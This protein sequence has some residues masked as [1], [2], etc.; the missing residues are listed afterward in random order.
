MS[1][2]FVRLLLVAALLFGAPYAAMILNRAMGPWSVVAIEADG[3]HTNMEFGAHLPRPHWVLIPPDAGIVQASRSV[4]KQWPDGLQTLNLMS[5]ASAEDIQAFY[6]NGLAA[7]GFV[8]RDLGTG[9][10]NRP[11]ADYLG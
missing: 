2:L 8:V 11:A 7:L 10:L 9:T 6:R 1:R 5:R 4:S 3:S